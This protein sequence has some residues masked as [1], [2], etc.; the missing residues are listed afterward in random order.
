MI[1][2]ICLKKQMIYLDLVI[3]TTGHILGPFIPFHFTIIAHFSMCE[4]FHE[5]SSCC[6]MA[7]VHFKNINKANI[8]FVG[9]INGDLISSDPLHWQNYF[10]VN[11]GDHVAN[12]R[13]P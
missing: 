3:P 6:R 8:I 11:C 12:G 2:V 10:A 13:I 7:F 5:T 9:N 4:L 1:Y